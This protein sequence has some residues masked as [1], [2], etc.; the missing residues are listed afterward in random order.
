MTSK[1]YI[2]I[3]IHCI[4]IYVKSLNFMIVHDS[5][6]QYSLLTDCTDLIV[7]AIW[8]LH[9]RQLEVIRCN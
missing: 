7:T 1:S 9:V 3:Y 2:Y 6:A 8:T 5:I 4:Y